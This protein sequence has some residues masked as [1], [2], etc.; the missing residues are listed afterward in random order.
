LIG[1]G[2]AGKGAEGV[3][4][5][6]GGGAI[7]ALLLFGGGCHRDS[8]PRRLCGPHL[9]A[10]VICVTPEEGYGAALPPIDGLD[11]EA[12]A[13]VDE[14]RAHPAGQFALRMFAEERHRVV[15]RS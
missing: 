2:A 9:I 11:Q 8:W 4:E 5:G 7:P 6:L 10:L 3:S 14:T 13:L 15:S 1:S 12:R